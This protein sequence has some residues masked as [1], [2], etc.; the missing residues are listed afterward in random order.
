MFVRQLSLSICPLRLIIPCCL[1]GLFQIS[2]SG[3]TVCLVMYSCG[4]FRWNYLYPVGPS[5]E[6]LE[7]TFMFY[8]KLHQSESQLP[9]CGWFCW[10]DIVWQNSTCFAVDN[11][12]VFVSLITSP[13]FC[14]N[15][16]SCTTRFR[17]SLRAHA[18]HGCFI[19]ALHSASCLVST[20]SE[21]WQCC[22]YFQQHSQKIT[23][24]T[25]CFDVKK[26]YRCFCFKI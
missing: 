24:T 16:S 17:W 26:V 2:P 14:S 6:V 5:I 12:A 4:C 1:T 25:Q 19:S 15:F 20:S 21:Y 13:R 3:E 22:L 8:E 18:R 9:F 11:E 10:I 23:G 7:N